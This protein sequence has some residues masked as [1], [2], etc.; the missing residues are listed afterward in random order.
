MKVL[1]ETRGSFRAGSGFLCLFVV[2]LGVLRE[3]LGLCAV[4]TAP[5]GSSRPDLHWGGATPDL[6]LSAKNLMGATLGRGARAVLTLPSSK[7]SPALLYGC[8]AAIKLPHAR[9]G[10]VLFPANPRFLRSLLEL[11]ISHGKAN[12]RRRLL[13]KNFA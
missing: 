13:E 1:G 6:G 12:E 10:A 11:C 7:G 5:G 4:L 3:H 9:A 8:F 2:S